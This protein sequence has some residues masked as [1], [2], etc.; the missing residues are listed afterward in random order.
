V[1]VMTG[2]NEDAAAIEAIRAGAA[3]YLLTDARIDDILRTIRGAG[4]G[5]VVLPARTAAR[6]VGLAGEQS[7]LSSRETE[8]LNLVARGLAN[9]QI[10]RELSITES[11]VKTHIGSLFCKLGLSSRTQLALYAARTGLVALDHLGS[12]TPVG[13]SDGLRQ[14]Q[15]EATS[16]ASSHRSTAAAT[17]RPA[18]RFGA[19]V[20]DRTAAGA[21]SAAPRPAGEAEQL[22][23][24]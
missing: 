4:A 2:V 16:G 12:E 19:A 20:V 8:V 17:G 10:A 5:Q 18:P 14:A 11:T 7:L 9:K 15:A 6:M 22:Q 24:W 13:Q 3:A 23:R 1:I 21:I